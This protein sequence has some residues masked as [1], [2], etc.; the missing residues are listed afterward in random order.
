MVFQC[1]TV[2]LEVH[3]ANV[4][5]SLLNPYKNI[6]YVWRKWQASTWLIN[7]GKHLNLY[8]K[9]LSSVILIS[10][11]SCWQRLWI[12]GAVCCFLDYFI[13]WAWACIFWL[14]LKGTINAENTHVYLHRRNLKAKQSPYGGDAVEPN[15]LEPF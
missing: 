14:K 2:C 5:S 4:K 8:S 6:R 7:G 11:R 10:S 12:R 13:A 1:T 3:M 15:N 9:R